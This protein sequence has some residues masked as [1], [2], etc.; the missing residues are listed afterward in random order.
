MMMANFIVS[1]N[2]GSTVTRHLLFALHSNSSFSISPADY[3]NLA[4]AGSTKFPRA[5]STKCAR[6]DSTTSSRDES[7]KSTCTE[8]T[9]FSSPQEFA[10][11]R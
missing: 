2:D 4:R 3:T 9:K 11:G 1:F 5:G 6:A 10:P 8:S 7:T